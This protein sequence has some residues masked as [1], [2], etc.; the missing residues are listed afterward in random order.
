MRGFPFLNLLIALILSGA[1]LLPL[2]W[3]STRGTSAPVAVRDEETAPAEN[4]VPA[5]VSLRF[6]HAPSKVRLTAGSTVLREWATPEGALL[7]E[8]TLPL[9]L[10]EER[11]EFG[12]K[13]EWPPGTTDPTNVVLEMEPERRESRK[14]V[15]WSSGGVVDEI[16]SFTWKP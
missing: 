6:V 1:V 11:T 14:A 7:L 12:L 10:S 15:Y 9:P 2:V 13:I 4:T 8:D 3:R 16:D 5:H